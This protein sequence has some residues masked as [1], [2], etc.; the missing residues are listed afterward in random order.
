MELTVGQR[1]LEN[2]EE[3]APGLQ[4]KVAADTLVAATSHLRGVR[5][6]QM[7][8]EEW[9]VTDSGA[10]VTYGINWEPFLVA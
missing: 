9:R 3:K 7:G 5:F 8:V 1:F 4:R 6:Y 2:S 10:G